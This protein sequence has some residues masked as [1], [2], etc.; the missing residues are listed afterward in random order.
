MRRDGA[1]SEGSPAELVPSL[2]VSP[3]Y[4]LLLAF[5]LFEVVGFLFEQ[6]GP[7]LVFLD[8][9]SFSYRLDIVPPVFGVYSHSID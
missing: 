4:V 7:V 8:L 5:D 1:G 3:V 6:L 2:L 9:L